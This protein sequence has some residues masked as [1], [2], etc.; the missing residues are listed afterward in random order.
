MIKNTK[1]K[2]FTMEDAAN[3]I[4]LYQQ[5]VPPV[6]FTDTKDLGASSDSEAKLNRYKASTEALLNFADEMLKKAEKT[7]QEQQKRIA[8]LE[9]LSTTDE[10]TAVA[11]RRG[12][13]DAFAAELER[14]NRGQSVGGVLL[15]IDL[16]EF[17]PINDTHGHAAGDECLKAVASMLDNEVRTM[18][19]VARFGGDEF[20]VLFSN[21]T[22]AQLF[23]RI[24][25]IIWQL[26]TLSVNW[27][28]ATIGIKASVGAKE[29]KA[30]VT[31]AEV[32]DAADL[33]LYE[34]KTRKQKVFKER[35]EITSSATN[36]VEYVARRD[37]ST[38]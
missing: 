4:E 33:E 36:V 10:L 25:Q 11:N 37:E 9:S 35:K 23:D 13:N 31:Q 21:T 7:I 22:A 26:N 2:G 32:F 8:H 20:A 27:P 6:L 15:V 12:F 1:G 34:Q 28:G 14:I 19:T 16:D 5:G 17:K 3:A 29:F 24:E 38:L 18:D 30:G